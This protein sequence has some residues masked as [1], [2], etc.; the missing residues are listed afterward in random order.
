MYRKSNNTSQRVLINS[1]ALT[2]L[3]VQFFIKDT[4]SSFSW[5]SILHSVSQISTLFCSGD[6]HFIVTILVPIDSLA[7]YL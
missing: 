3:L 1:A 2:R 6:P 7:T 4:L 5:T